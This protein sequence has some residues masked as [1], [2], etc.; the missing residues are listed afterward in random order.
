RIDYR[1]IIWSLVK[2]PDAFARYR[3]QEA[4]FPTIE[5][6]RAYDRFQ[7]AYGAGRRADVAYLQLLHHAAATMEIGV[8]T[9]LE[10][11]LEAGEVPTLDRVK[12]LIGA[13]QAE[14]PELSSME[15]DLE[16]YNDL[17]TAEES[18]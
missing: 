15:V 18:R 1:H 3:H 14:V 7:E 5:F 10:L 4:L 8:Q 2:K 11:L 13:E 17:L 16:E 9:A 12:Q 6:R